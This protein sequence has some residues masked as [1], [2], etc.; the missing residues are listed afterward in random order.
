MP[1]SPC[2]KTTIVDLMVVER[3]WVACT[4]GSLEKHRTP[5]LRAYREISVCRKIKTTKVEGSEN[6][7]HSGPIPKTLQRFSVMK[8][9]VVSLEITK[10]ALTWGKMKE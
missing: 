2:Y 10:K 8:L 3:P 5:K 4:G 1:G 9:C 6:Q 7:D